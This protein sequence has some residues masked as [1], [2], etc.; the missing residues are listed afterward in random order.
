MVLQ[1]MLNPCQRSCTP[2]PTA[3]S[4]SH[5]ETKPHVSGVGVAVYSLHVGV[6]R[7]RSDTPET[8]HSGKALFIS[9]MDSW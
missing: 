1:K 6:R 2:G 3:P 4:W 9:S 8:P 5:V 7:G